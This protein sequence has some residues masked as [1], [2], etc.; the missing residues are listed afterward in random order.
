VD[1]T[2]TADEE[3]LR[4]GVRRLCAGRFPMARVRDA[5]ATGGL[6][7]AGWA[8][9]SDAGVFALL[10]PDGLGL[11]MAGAVVVCEELGRA[12]VPGP[13]VGSILAA[14]WSDGPVTAVEEGAGERGAAVLSHLGASAAVLV[15]AGTGAELVPATA[16]DRARPLRPL[17]PL[18][19]VWSA[20]RPLPPGQVVADGPE[21]RRLVAEGTLLTAALLTGAAAGALDLALGYVRQREQ[22]GRPVGSFQAIKHLMADML[23]RVELARSATYAAA[24][25]L[26]ESAGDSDRA[27]ASAKVMAGDAAI[28]NGETAVQAHGGMGFTW[29]VDAHLYLKRAWVLDQDFGSRDRQALTLASLI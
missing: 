12:L 17:D 1:L 25:G 13:L 14:G 15:L 18:T 4:Q 2:L 23:V 7:P 26:D 27:V 3:D 9:L 24:A 8:E 21:A 6:D 11:G 19:P 20:D 16:L 10:Q 5:E 22:F 28:R 29:E